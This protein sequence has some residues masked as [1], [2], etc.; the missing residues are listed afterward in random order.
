MAN[1][2]V[3][4]LIKSKLWFGAAGVV[5]AWMS[6][7]PDLMLQ[8]ILAYTGAE[9]TQNVVGMVK[10]GTKPSG[11]TAELVNTLKN[12]LKRDEGVPI[13]YETEDEAILDDSGANEATPD[14]AEETPAA[15]EV[16]ATIKPIN[17]E[18][19]IDGIKKNL[20]ADLVPIGPEIV[21]MK[22]HEWVLRNWD[23]IPA[24]D[25]ARVLDY[26]IGL[27][28]EHYRIV[29]G[30][31]APATGEEMLNYNQYLASLQPQLTEKYGCGKYPA[32][33]VRVAVFDLRD[34]Y[35]FK[36]SVSL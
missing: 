28:R 22:F 34:L 27:A 19:V 24:F 21:S 14:V 6:N 29:V 16:V 3:T 20:T 36:G 13:P 11:D 2:L 35:I 4:K 33:R 17:I 7:N 25:Q 23:R 15:E 12:L 9:V 31:A 32:E 10:N 5:Y 26:A 30:V 18:M 1:D 8:V